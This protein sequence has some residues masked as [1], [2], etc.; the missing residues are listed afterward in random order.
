MIAINDLMSGRLERGGQIC[1]FPFTDIILFCY[2]ERIN[3]AAVKEW[4]RNQSIFKHPQLN[5]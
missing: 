3:G 1:T 4:V 5:I 2:T